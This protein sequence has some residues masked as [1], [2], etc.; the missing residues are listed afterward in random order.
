MP[1]VKFNDIDLHYEIQGNGSPL[2]LISGMGSDSLSWFSIVK[3]LSQHHLVIT[4][5]NRGIGRTKPQDIEISIQQMTNDYIALIKYLGLPSV[6]I[7][8]H[9]MG[10]F[11]A[12]D[13]A[14]R[15]PELISKLMLAGTSAFNSEWNNALYRQWVFH[16]E[17]G[18]EFCAWFRNVFYWLFS[19]RIL[20]DKE[21]LNDIIQIAVENP[22]RQSKIAF[23]NQVKAIEKFNCVEE[24]L[25]I[26]TETMVLC[27]KED[28]LFPPEETIKVLQ[29]IP[30][31]RF[32]IIENAAHSIH[33]ENP[34]E[35]T[36]CVLNFLRE[37]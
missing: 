13:C 16:L 28:I 26:K 23:A 18:M 27:G 24:L 8:G 37:S 6:N 33:I 31:V 2:L 35:F 4:P 1:S 34:K 29:A 17:S 30:N 25:H 22:Y 3:K 20:D 10:G 36:D 7:L 14:I 11:V 15:Y 19:K 5:D 21:Y 9:S 32:S 12:L